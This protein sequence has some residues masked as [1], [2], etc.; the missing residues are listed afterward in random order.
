VLR[1]RIVRRRVGTFEVVSLFDYETI[2]P[3]LLT[4][5]T[6]HGHRIFRYLGRRFLMPF[7]E[8]YVQS[9]PA[10]SR[11]HLMAVDDR[12]RYGYAHT[13]ALVHR[14]RWDNVYLLRSALRA[15]TDYSYAGKSLAWRLEHPRRF[16]YRG[17]GGIEAIVVDDVVTTG[18]T[19]QEAQQCLQRAHVE[20]LFAVTLADADR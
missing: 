3:L 15:Q 6:P 12:P 4:K 11:L 1:V 19:L 9:L 20:L 13:A 18:L 2:A 14:S 17:P 7:L 16:R 8:H 10:S 5:H